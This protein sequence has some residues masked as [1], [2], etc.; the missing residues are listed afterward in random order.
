MSLDEYLAAWATS[1][2]LP[3]ATATEIYHRIVRPPPT[4]HASPGLDPTWWRRFTA[5]FT[6][7]MVASTRPTTWAA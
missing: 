5:D 3:D 2:R 7:R 6:A 4:T 1:I